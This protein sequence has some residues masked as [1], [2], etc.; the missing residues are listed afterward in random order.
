MKTRF[1]TSFQLK[2]SKMLPNGTAPIYLRITIG[3][4][5]VEL[6]TKKYVQPARWNPAAQKV[7]GNIEEARALNAYLKTMEQE[8]FQAHQAL[9]LESKEVTAANIKSKLLGEDTEQHSI[10]D[11]FK[12]HNKKMEALVGKQYARATWK[13]FETTLKHTQDFI[14]WKYKVPDLDVSRL[15]H[16][17]L[18]NFEFYLKSV[19]DCDHNAT[20]K[21][22]ANFKKVVLRCVKNGWISK[23]PFNGFKLSLREVKINVLT[24]QELDA[25]AKKAFDSARVGKVRDIFLFSCYTGLA[26]ADVKKLKR[27]EIR[28]GLDGKNWI[29]A[30][31]Q[32]T[33]TDFRIPL[34]PEAARIL[35]KFEDNPQCANMD[36]AFPVMSNQ[37]MNAYLKE[38]GDLCGIKKNLTYHLARHTFA[39][40]VTLSNGVPMETV[41]KMLGHKNL[42]TTQ[43]YAKI[44][45]TKISQDMDGLRK[46]RS[47]KLSQGI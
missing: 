36:R 24:D 43:H 2:Q 16:E 25:I 42:K 46:R 34:L 11:E 40:T 20:M 23:D 47:K 28:Q 4:D 22:L 27:S 12:D 8:V 9:I 33:E 14:Q 41:S 39:T 17:F 26:Y 29:F 6:S 7:S 30:S 37:K 15:N 21:Y 1:T 32:K 10:I 31:R 35:K 13:R 38:I 5:R 3:A 44:V 18:E 45:D 19:R